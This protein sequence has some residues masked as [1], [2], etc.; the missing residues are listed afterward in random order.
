MGTPTLRRSDITPRPLRTSATNCGREHLLHESTLHIYG[1]YHQK[2]LKATKEKDPTWC[3]MKTT[4]PYAVRAVK[5]FSSYRRRTKDHIAGGNV[6]LCNDNSNTHK[7]R[8]INGWCNYAYFPISRKKLFK[9]TIST[10]G[11][12]SQ[13]YFNFFKLSSTPPK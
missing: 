3:K 13:I 2:N 12:V 11:I 4:R 8:S 10:R 6:L 1:K 7:A 9:Y 5:T